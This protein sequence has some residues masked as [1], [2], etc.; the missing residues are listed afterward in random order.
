MTELKE[1]W[2][3]IVI[4]LVLYDFHCRITQGCEQ[5]GKAISMDPSA[6]LAGLLLIVSFSMSHSCVQI[7]GT[8]WREPVLNWISI[9]LQTG[10]RKSTLC[11]Y[12]KDIL[13]VS[14]KH[15]ANDSDKESWLCDDQSFEQLYG[16]EQWVRRT[17][18][19]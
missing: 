13:R 16:A 1:V 10:M 18:K 7:E 14:K 5:I 6:V 11:K 15:C 8:D 19:Y 2:A 17:S 3:I 4:H 9:A 12:L